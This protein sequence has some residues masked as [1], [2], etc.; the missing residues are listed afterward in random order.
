MIMGDFTTGCFIRAKDKEET[1][2]E[3]ANW[4][5]SQHKHQQ[6]SQ[7]VQGLISDVP[8]VQGISGEHVCNA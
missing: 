2:K 5:L 6:V 3:N 8:I 4:E 7:A 1:V